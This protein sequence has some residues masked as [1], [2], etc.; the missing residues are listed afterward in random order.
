[1]LKISRLLNDAPISICYL[2]LEY[3]RSNEKKA[4]TKLTNTRNGSYIL[5]YS[6]ADIYE[7]SKFIEFIS[8]GID[9]YGFKRTFKS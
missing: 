9:Y 3:L 7:I 1:M 5:V 6:L 2:P 8:N 4:T